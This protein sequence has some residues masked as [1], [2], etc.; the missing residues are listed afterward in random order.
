[1]GRRLTS[2][3]YSLATPF[4]DFWPLL[5]DL[6]SVRAREVRPSANPLAPPPN[7]PRPTRAQPLPIRLASHPLLRFPLASPHRPS[8]A[9]PPLAPPPWTAAPGLL[10]ARMDGTVEPCGGSERSGGPR[11]SLK[12]RCRSGWARTA[13]V[14][15]A[16]GL[17]T[18]G[19]V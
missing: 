17:V 3:Y 8:S 6:S 9:T 10:P 16:Q 2:K 13:G 15:R 18:R 5:C 19:P 1:M 11:A 12:G 4:S 7:C 14:S